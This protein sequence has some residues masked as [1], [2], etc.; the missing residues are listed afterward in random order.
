MLPNPNPLSRIFNTLLLH[1][2]QDGAR[3]IRLESGQIDT[4][5]EVRMDDTRTIN[6]GPGQKET[7]VEFLIGETW[8]PQLQIPG[9][10]F[11][12]LAA[13]IEAM[14][15]APGALQ[16]RFV[17]SEFGLGLDLSLGLERTEVASGE[18]L[19]ISLGKFD[20]EGNYNSKSR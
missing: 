4:N 18:R 19:E 8:R 2:L 7:Q 20:F 1:A 16:L 10:V 6:F 3:A 17:E 5:L 11:A 9:Y 13:H 12:P 15:N 14:Q